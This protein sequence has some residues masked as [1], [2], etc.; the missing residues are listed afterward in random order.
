[1]TVLEVQ[2][3]FPYMTEGIEA[4]AAAC[5]DTSSGRV[6]ARPY[7]AFDKLKRVRTT[8]LPSFSL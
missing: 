6:A 2:T 7:V 1:M 3:R 5:A 4:M 8:S